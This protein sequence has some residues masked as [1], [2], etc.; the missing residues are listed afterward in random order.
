MPVPSG[1]EIKALASRTIEE[2]TVVFV[3]DGL[4][5]ELSLARWAALGTPNEVK[6]T[7]QA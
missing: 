7:K 5:L 6:I 1:N 3:G 4:R 2:D